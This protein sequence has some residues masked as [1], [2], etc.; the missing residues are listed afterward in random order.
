LE[1]IKNIVL[2][3]SGNVATQLAS[4]FV[5]KG[6]NILQVYSYHAAH[7]ETLANIIGCRPTADLGKLNKDADLYIIAVKDDAI[8][9]LN[10]RLLRLH[11]KLV[12]HTSGSV[13]LGA[14][15]RISER[16]GV[17]Y[18]LQTFTK[19]RAVNWQSIPLCIEA[20]DK[21][22]QSSL[23]QFAGRITDSVFDIDSHTRRK[24]HLA[25]VFANNFTNYLLG[26][27]KEIIGADLPF[28]ILKP[29]V[30]E[31]LDKAFE[32]VPEE[33]QTGPALRGD[34]KTM[35]AHLELLSHNTEAQAL[36]NL[37]SDFIGKKKS[38]S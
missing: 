28:D 30:Q 1:N 21:E 11:N 26:L 7:A 19:N 32:I 8:S 20:N 27:S 2:I 31:T 16:T 37:I 3:G 4:V 33:A 13:P 34:V 15:D 29:L 14:I 35:E 22:V 38:Q 25:A 36:Y 9:T 12:V 6:V 24:L 18:P 17:F 10:D 5:A 23:H